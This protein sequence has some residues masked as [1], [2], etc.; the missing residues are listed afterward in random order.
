[1]SDPEPL[2]PKWFA[3]YPKLPDDDR[4]NVKRF[5]T[6]QDARQFLDA[7]ILFLSA[8]PTPGVE[9]GEPGLQRLPVIRNRDQGWWGPVPVLSLRDFPGLA[10]QGSFKDFL[11]LESIGTISRRPIRKQIKRLLTGRKA[12]PICTLGDDWRF[13][14]IERVANRLVGHEF[15]GRLHDSIA[16]ILCKATYDLEESLIRIH[17]EI[18][19]EALS[20]FWQSWDVQR[21]LAEFVGEITD[22]GEALR[23]S[24]ANSTALSAAN[25]AWRF[26]CEQLSAYAY[27]LSGYIC[28]TVTPTVQGEIA[29][30]PEPQGPAVETRGIDSSSQVSDSILHEHRAGET[31]RGS[32][33]RTRRV[34][35]G[36]LRPLEGKRVVSFSTAQ[37]YL[38]ISERQRQKLV[39]KGVLNVEGGGHNKK[40]TTES[41]MRYLPPENPN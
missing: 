11:P 37:D 5:A 23:L 8:K 25:E 34:R 14:D 29:G 27:H 12:D 4:R 21:H 7:E 24:G 39:E 15:E 3:V 13:S 40:I 41:L 2:P 9:H 19:C 36:D 38:G 28:E 35:K 18:S 10:C 31:E 1:M 30:T 16:E 26:V 6:E 32:R 22:S 20:F 17:R 33:E